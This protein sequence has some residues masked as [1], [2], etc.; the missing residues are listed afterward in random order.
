M[1][2]SAY[3]LRPYQTNGIEAVKEQWKKGARAVVLQ[4]PCGSGKTVEFAAIAGDFKGRILSLAHRSELIHQAAATLQKSLGG[5]EVGIVE[6]GEHSLGNRA[7]V[8]TI[9]SLLKLS[10]DQ[11]PKNVE[12]LIA[13]ECH[14]LP[15]HSWRQTV[16]KLYPD[17][18]ILGA[19]AT[20]IH[21]SG[22]TMRSVF[23]EMIPGPQYEELID[24]GFLSKYQLF[25]PPRPVNLATVTQWWKKRAG[26]MPTII[27]AKSVSQSQ[28]LIQYFEK[29]GI[30]IAHL[31]AHTPH[32]QR[33]K[34][35]D[36]L[37]SGELQV[38]SNY[39]ILGEG[40]DIPR[41]GCVMVLRQMGLVEFLQAGSRSLRHYDGKQFAVIG[42]FFSNWQSHGLVSDR[43]HWSLDGTY[44]ERQNPRTR[45]R[46]CARVFHF[47]RSG[48]INCPSCNSEISV[49]YH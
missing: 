16:T 10:S 35:L 38:I 27:F 1:I 25:S 36:Q 5:E 17:T 49:Y 15:A 2:A 39:K 41:V 4:Q 33:L 22:D 28:L 19:T 45:C 14:H 42:D 46:H 11:L 3:E 24:Q 44:L 48:E 18:K 23:D 31:D 8:A 6:H 13:D 47:D 29:E 9:Q 7:T 32:D 21:P 20:P 40:L 12:L 34:L 26:G 30:S 43:R 37:R